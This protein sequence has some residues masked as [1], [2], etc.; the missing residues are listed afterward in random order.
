MCESK[1]VDGG[2]SG[3]EGYG[4]AMEVKRMS[5]EAMKTSSSFDRKLNEMIE[6]LA[7]RRKK[8]L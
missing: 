1:E 2:R 8:G 5:W 7:L 6:C 4:K 3:E